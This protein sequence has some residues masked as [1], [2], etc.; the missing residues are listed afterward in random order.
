MASARRLLADDDIEGAHPVATPS[1]DHLDRGTATATAT[2]VNMLNELEGAGILGLSF[3]I[4]LAGWGALGCL[5]LVGSMAAFTGWCLAMCM[6]E[7]DT[8]RRVRQS[9]AA[10]GRA[11]F[12]SKGERAVVVVQMLN[13]VS[14]GVVYLV[15]IAETMHVL[16]P[17]LRPEE[18]ASDSWAWLAMADRRLWTLT[19]TAAVLPSV[20]VGGYKKLWLMSAL[21]L[22]CLMTIIVLG[23]AD[24]ASVIANRGGSIDP[25]PSVNWGQVPAAYSIFVFAFSAHGIFPDLEASM[26]EPAKFPRVVGGVF[27]INMVLKTA[28]ALVGFFGFGTSVQQ[29]LTNNLSPIPRLAVSILIVANTALAFPLP[30]IPVFRFL[31]GR[32]MKS[33]EGGAPRAANE[34]SPGIQAVQRTLV[35]LVCGLV[36]ACIPDFALAMGFM[37][38]LTLAFLTFIFPCAFY[39]RIHHQRS[40]VAVKVACVFVIVMGVLGSIAGI[41]SNIALALSGE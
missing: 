13:L 30:L 9:Y 20:H 17:I 31:K 33:P 39:L 16:L 7:P 12:G 1:D 8:G 29:V 14:V 37:G 10:A 25:V 23:I 35:V 6:Y 26:K 2:A 32:R 22:V 40:S 3:A 5:L 34:H 28:F 24:S 41:A 38:S 21:G 36:A 11:A 27:A 18:A 15:L 19:A 4:S